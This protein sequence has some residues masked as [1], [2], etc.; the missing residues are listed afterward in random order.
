MAASSEP[1]A[2]ILWAG[3]GRPLPRSVR[4]DSMRPFPGCRLGRAACRRMTRAVVVVSVRP[5]SRFQPQTVAHGR[6]VRFTEP[7]QTPQSDPRGI[8]DV[9]LCARDG[10]VCRP[11]PPRGCDPQDRHPP[12]PHRKSASPYGRDRLGHAQLDRPGQRR[13]RD[14]PPKAPAVPAGARHGRS[15]ST[16]P[17]AA[18]T[19]SPAWPPRSAS[20]P[21]LRRWN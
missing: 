7:P 21:A 8:G 11:R 3:A 10:G 17:A 12:A 2:H 18:S 6:S 16:S 20:T 1:A 13:P 14:L 4:T 9:R 5:A 15:S 19:T